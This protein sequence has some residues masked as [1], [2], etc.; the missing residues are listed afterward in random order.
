MISGSAVETGYAIGG[1]GMGIFS[2]LSGYLF[3]VVPIDFLE[4]YFSL[5]VALGVFTVGYSTSYKK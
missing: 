3:F 4:I 2:I 5:I 1:I